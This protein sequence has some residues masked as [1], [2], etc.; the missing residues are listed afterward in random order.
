MTAFA[1]IKRDANGSVELSYTGTLRERDARHIC[2]DAVFALPDR[3]LG[4]VQLQRGDHFREWFYAGRWYNIFRVSAAQSRALKG[5]YCN[6]TRPPVFGDNSVAADDLG[7]DV[8]VYP[9]GKTLLLDKSDFERL[10]LSRAEREQAW[11]AVADI[12]SR[13]QRRQP[14]FDEITT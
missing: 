7:L 4:Y 5:W 10:P 8:F 2:I 13:V 6:I 1:V 9:D 11:A 3:D 12:K 14:P